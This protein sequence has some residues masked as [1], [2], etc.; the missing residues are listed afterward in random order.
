MAFSPIYYYKKNRKQR[1]K[2]FIV[3]GVACLLYIAALYGYEY[4]SSKSV[5]EN[6]RSIYIIAFSV[7]SFILFYVA[8]RHRAYSATY[9]AVITTDRFIVKYPGPPMWSFDIKISDIKR[10]E[11]RNT[12]SHAGKGDLVNLFI[13][14]N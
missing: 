13:Q 1:S 8:W 6:T 4:I 9:E 10:F 3:M 7:C 12:L 11:H 5:P 14:P 2:I